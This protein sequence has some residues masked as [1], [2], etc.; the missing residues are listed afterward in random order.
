[1][2]KKLLLISAICALY[3][4]PPVSVAQTKSHLEG[5]WMI[6][7]VASEASVLGRSDAGKV[8]SL[9]LGA[10]YFG[11]SYFEFNAEKLYFGV[12]PGSDKS[13]EYSRVS[14]HG[15]Q[16]T[17]L[18]K[19]DQK[20]GFQSISVRIVDD[21]SIAI[22]MQGYDGFEHLRWKRTVLDSSNRRPED[23]QPRINAFLKMITRFLEASK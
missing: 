2:I 3:L 21:Q 20:N 1:M 4:I 11:L 12:L 10:R 15:G 14:S 23:F 22:A 19:T 18:P 9:V 8:S 7:P 6:D 5:K 16:S 17:Y 13:S